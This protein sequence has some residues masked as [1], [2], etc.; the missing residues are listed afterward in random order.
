M[1]LYMVIYDKR[2]N[3]LLKNYLFL[4]YFVVRYIYNFHQTI[5]LEN[6]ITTK[7]QKKKKTQNQKEIFCEEIYII[8][9]FS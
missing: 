6:F 8:I 4:K 2:I 7:F 1:K 9:N 3:C 5:F